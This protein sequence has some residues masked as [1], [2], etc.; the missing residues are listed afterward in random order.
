MWASLLWRTTAQ[1]KDTQEA[2]GLQNPS[3]PVAFVPRETGDTALPPSVMND[4]LL[5]KKTKREGKERL[6]RRGVTG[7]HSRWGEWKRVAR[8]HSIWDRFPRPHS[9]RREKTVPS[10]IRSYYLTGPRVSRKQTVLYL[11]DD[12]I[13]SPRGWRATPFYH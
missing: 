13:P 11:R 10:L 1:S 2:N 7:P 8:F 12:M 5:D 4:G 9:K 3:C 6:R